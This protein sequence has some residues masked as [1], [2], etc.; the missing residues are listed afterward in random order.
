MN[1]WS[2]AIWLLI[3]LY[4]YKTI[5][6]YIFLKPQKKCGIKTRIWK[7]KTR[8]PFT[9]TNAPGPHASQVEHEIRWEKTFVVVDQIPLLQQCGLMVCRNTS[10]HQCLSGHSSRPFRQCPLMELI[11]GTEQSINLIIWRPIPIAEWWWPRQFQLSLSPLQ[12]TPLWVTS[13]AFECGQCG[14]NLS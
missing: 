10:G 14:D 6:N 5:E 13:V 1:C 9:C 3:P 12:Q 7:P 2:P 11:G 4:L 8:L